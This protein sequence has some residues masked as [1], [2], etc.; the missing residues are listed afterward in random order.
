MGQHSTPTQTADYVR[1]KTA[2][3]EDE[4]NPIGVTCNCPSAAGHGRRSLPSY[5]CSMDGYVRLGRA[6]ATEL[7]PSSFAYD[8][9]FSKLSY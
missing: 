6:A 7:R 4:G 9:N 2:R 3:A 5:A 1:H 8:Q